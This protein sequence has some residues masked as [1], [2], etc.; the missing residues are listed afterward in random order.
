[1]GCIALARNTHTR[2][3][4]AGMGDFFLGNRPCNGTA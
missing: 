2:T 3:P 4:M 1:M